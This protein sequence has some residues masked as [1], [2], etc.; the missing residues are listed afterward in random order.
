[1]GCGT[2]REDPV[3][4]DDQSSSSSGSRPFQSYVGRRG[5]MYE[6]AQGAPTTA[7]LTD[8]EF[9]SPPQH[10]LP[11]VRIDTS[12]AVPPR[13]PPLQSPPLPAAD[14][15]R[16]ETVVNSTPPPQRSATQSPAPAARPLGPLSTPFE[17][18]DVA[19]FDQ[20]IAVARPESPG[21]H[22]EEP[23]V[24]DR[25]R[26]EEQIVQRAHR[27]H[28]INGEVDQ[29]DVQQLR[30]VKKSLLDRICQWVDSVI[31]DVS[32]PTPAIVDVALTPRFNGGTGPSTLLPTLTPVVLS[33]S[34]GAV[35]TPENRSFVGMSAAQLHNFSQLTLPGTVPDTMSQ[36]SADDSATLPMG[37]PARPRKPTRGL[38]V[39]PPSSAAN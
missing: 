11:Q 2:S 3:V 26:V 36:V 30:I 16:R 29:F 20:L 1:M 8:E 28:G 37:S 25:S 39:T 13:A 19:V 23:S 4:P 35:G 18:G 14:A 22:C 9:H 17:P 27:Q 38:V 34:H 21:Q 7:V 6:T 15:V 12:P 24:L 32:C 31:P 5:R 10:A 33:I